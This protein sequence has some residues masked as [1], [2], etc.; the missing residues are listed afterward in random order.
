[1]DRGKTDKLRLDEEKRERGELDETEDVNVHP[2]DSEEHTADEKRTV[3]AKQITGD[4]FSY[5]LLN[6]LSENTDANVADVH[7]TL[8]DAH[9]AVEPR[10]FSRPAVGENV[11][12][13]E[14]FRMHDYPHTLKESESND[15]T[16][17]VVHMKT[18]AEQ[19][20][21]ERLGQAVTVPNKQTVQL[22][23]PE[24][25]N[26]MQTDKE[27]ENVEFV[28]VSLQATTINELLERLPHKLNSEQEQAFKIIA[29]HMLQTVKA[30]A[31]GTDPPPQLLLLIDGPA[32]TGK[33]VI[34]KAI[35]TLVQLLNLQETYRK[36]AY[37]GAA[38]DNIGGETLHRVLSLST[39]DNSDGHTKAGQRSKTGAHR[40]GKNELLPSIKYLCIDEVFTIG[41]RCLNEVNENLQA[42]NSKPNEPFGGVSIFCAGDKYQLPPIGDLSLFRTVDEVLADEENDNDENGNSARTKAS[43]HRRFMEYKEGQRAWHQLSSNVV[44]L[45]QIVRQANP[46][47][48]ALLNRVRIQEATQA[49]VDRLNQQLF[50]PTNVAHQ[51]IAEKAYYIVPTNNLRDMINHQRVMRQCVNQGTPMYVV[52]ALHPTLTNIP[53]IQQQALR[54][55]LMQ[56][57]GSD[58][59]PY[60]IET[61]QNMPITFTHNDRN[62]MP[63]GVVNG[64]V[65]VFKYF[66]YSDQEDEWAIRSVDADGSPFIFQYMPKAAVIEIPN[67]TFK[68]GNLPVA[69]IMIF[70]ITVPTKK[71]NFTYMD[72]IIDKK[73]SVT[74]TNVPRT[75]FNFRPNYAGTDYKTQGKTIPFAIGKLPSGS[76][77]RGPKFGQPYVIFSRVPSLL[78]FFLLSPVKL[79]DL[80]VTS[81]TGLK[82]E[83][84]RLQTNNEQTILRY[85]N[86]HQS[87]DDEPFTS[88]NDSNKHNPNA[89]PFYNNTVPENGHKLNIASQQ[90]EPPTKKKNYPQPKTMP[91]PPKQNTPATPPPKSTKANAKKRTQSDTRAETE[92][93]LPP[94][95]KQKQE[96]KRTTPFLNS[97]SN[98]K[99]FIEVHHAPVADHPP[100][101]KQKQQ[102]EPA[103]SSS[104]SASNSQTPID[105]DAV[106][107]MPPSVFTPAWK[108]H[109]LTWL[110]QF[111]NRVPPP[112][113]VQENIW[114]AL[115]IRT[116]RNNLNQIPNIA[117]RDIPYEYIFTNEKFDWEH[118][119]RL[120]QHGNGFTSDQVID[121]I[122]SSW[123]INV[124]NIALIPA[125]TTQIIYSDP[126]YFKP[127][128]LNEL[129]RQLLPNVNVVAAA[130]VRS[131]HIVA[132]SLDLS[133]WSASFYDSLANYQT[134]I[135]THDKNTINTV[136]R[137]MHR[138]RSLISPS[139]II[140]PTHALKIVRAHGP[141]QSDASSCGLYSL[142]FLHTQINNV[143]YS[144]N[145]YN[146]P[147]YLRAWIM[148][149]L[150]NIVAPITHA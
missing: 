111:P 1:M 119:A 34:I 20:Q 53:R 17:Y 120:A 78:N 115:D 148:Q 10:T 92:N 35:D 44:Q 50:D 3:R 109:T 11:E 95:K 128:G 135:S 61:H 118:F 98:S 117:T 64:G 132:F 71:V 74:L 112:E 45:S 52:E 55:A 139:N 24:D 80:N 59:L 73:Q 93:Q 86:T 62:Y 90:P 114:P 42:A 18:A 41:L 146:H 28:H 121:N 130:Y 65:G 47:D 89:P 32:G 4:D 46:D 68:V 37:T 94:K 75:T 29:R 149:E 49:D 122:I 104:N 25:E 6:S 143:I 36:A 102:P 23:N 39:I 56:E 54:K 5:T 105:V 57:N 108:Q 21:K 101:K 142:G 96:A 140:T 85:E 107:A 145:F 9:A 147:K 66:I 103:S 125:T 87:I 7:K 63:L 144:D 40:H 2:F 136:A 138:I 91:I 13:T 83:L 110:A 67:A 150:A 15:M 51:E 113:N 27:P 123:Q 8:V 82:E 77:F 99:T 126:T 116:V 134:A 129:T 69:H 12:I 137:T 76:G 33:S 31:A 79:E 133:T 70:P 81:P 38:A 14:N 84:K 72:P 97:I 88:F 100:N 124:Q 127:E 19:T 22:P 106:I 131:N 48:I 43:A 26:K 141:R 58:A 16:A 60:F 30:K